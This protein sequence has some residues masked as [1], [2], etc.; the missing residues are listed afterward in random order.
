VQGFADLP[1]LLPVRYAVI[2]PL[3]ITQTEEN[4]GDRD[5]TNSLFSPLPPVEKLAEK[6]A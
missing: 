6:A 5:I 2:F 3:V 4:R 1:A